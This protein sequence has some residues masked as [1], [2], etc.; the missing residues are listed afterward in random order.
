MTPLGRNQAAEQKRQATTSEQPSELAIL[1]APGTAVPAAFK[2][3]VSTDRDLHEKKHVFPRSLGTR[4]NLQSKGLHACSDKTLAFAMSGRE[5]NP[6]AAAR[7]E[8]ERR[9]R[10]HKA[11]M[12]IKKAKELAECTFK[13]SVS[14]KSLEQ[15][16]PPNTALFGSLP[17]NLN[18]SVVQSESAN[19]RRS[20]SQ[21]SLRSVRSRD[22]LEMTMDSFSDEHHTHD[23]VNFDAADTIILMPQTHHHDTHIKHK[24]HYP[25]QQNDNNQQPD[26]FFADAVDAPVTAKS[27]SA[28]FLRN[29]PEAQPELPH[30][31]CQAHQNAVQQIVY[32]RILNLPEPILSPPARLK[33]AVGQYS[34]EKGTAM[35]HQMRYASDPVQPLTSFHLESSLEFGSAL[36]SSILNSDLFNSCTR[37]SSRTPGDTQRLPR[38]AASKGE[39][40]A[41]AARGIMSIMSQIPSA[42]R[43]GTT[44]TLLHSHHH[45]E[46][47]TSSAHISSILAPSPVV[48]R[49]GWGNGDDYNEHIRHDPNLQRGSDSQGLQGYYDSTYVPHTLTRFSTSPSHLQS[50][51]VEE[52]TRGRREA[53]GG[54]GA[55]GGREREGAKGRSSEGERGRMRLQASS[56]FM[57]RDSSSSDLHDFVPESEKSSVS[58][59]TPR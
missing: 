50:N 26:D 30:T 19:G 37:R 44:G 32:N 33:T 13:P 36:S 51:V 18:P 39:Q 15:P 55:L 47:K 17:R 1:K 45:S 53:G 23:L 14:R 57:G 34:Q 11:A 10:L 8:K 7:E 4:S 2:M 24:E 35:Q 9:E 56:D 6:T 42:T 59:Q 49:F 52:P 28:V 25:S 31:G 43:A 27:E 46:Y 54:G 16:P 22:S 41:D 21:E 12:E 5:Y 58:V 3:K 40:Q 29:N 20:R 38:H 48:P